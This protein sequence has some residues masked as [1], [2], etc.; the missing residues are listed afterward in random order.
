MKA[1]QE[2]LQHAAECRELA[3]RAR[4]ADDREMILKMAE[5]W[6]ELATNREKMLR[7]LALAD[8]AL[9]TAGPK[10]DNLE[11]SP[12]HD[13]V[14]PADFGS[15]LSASFRIPGPCPDARLTLLIFPAGIWPSACRLPATII[16][17]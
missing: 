6:E 9:D 16:A 14:S 5:T 1:I 15:S 4:T 12:P 17:T 3:A 13:Q 8:Q 11:W 10:S 7:T 2:Y